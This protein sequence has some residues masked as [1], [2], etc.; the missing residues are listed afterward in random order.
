MLRVVLAIVVVVGAL[1]AI[2]FLPDNYRL[3]IY[4]LG[5]ISIC[6]LTGGRAGAGFARAMARFK[7]WLGF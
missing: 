4:I 7:A 2:S 3:L 5:F 1:T 6:A